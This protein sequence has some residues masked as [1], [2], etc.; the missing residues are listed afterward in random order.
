MKK[1]GNKQWD[2]KK[3][4]RTDPFTNIPP[5][6]STLSSKK[7]QK[8]LANHTKGINDIINH[9]VALWITRNL[10]KSVLPAN[11]KGIFNIAVQIE[12]TEKTVNSDRD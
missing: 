2:K 3:Q 12:E 4:F 9:S 1:E 8:S 10:K 5:P 11:K 7:F 6:P